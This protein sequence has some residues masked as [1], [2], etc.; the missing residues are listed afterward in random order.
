[1]KFSYQLRYFFVKNKFFKL[2]YYSAP[3]RSFAIANGEKSSYKLALGQLQKFNP[4]AKQIT[5][6]PAAKR[7]QEKF[8]ENNLILDLDWVVPKSVQMSYGSG[9]Q[10]FTAPAVYVGGLSMLFQAIRVAE[11]ACLKKTK[12][13]A[14]FINDAQWPIY[15]QSGLQLHA[16]GTQYPD[17]TTWYL[18]KKIIESNSLL[19]KKSPFD[20]DYDTLHLP[21]GEKF[22]SNPIYNSYYYSLFFLKQIVHDLASVN[23]IGFNDKMLAK[24]VIQALNSYQELNEKIL[25]SIGKPITVH[26]GRLF[27]SRDLDGIFMR[28][29]KWREM[30]IPV[31]FCSID[32]I[33]AKTILRL[34]GERPIYAFGMFGKKPI[35][36]ADGYVKPHIF[37]TSIQYAM[38]CFPE[39]FEYKKARLDKIFLD[40]KSKKPYKLEVTDSSK[41]A[42]EMEVSDFQGSLG[43]AEVFEAGRKERACKEFT[44]TGISMNFVLTISLEKLVKRKLGGTKDREFVKKFI[45][46]NGIIPTAG[47]YNL[48]VTIFDQEIIFENGEEFVKLYCRVTEGANFNVKGVADKRD[49]FNVI[50]KLEIF[51]EGAIELVPAGSCTRRTWLENMPRFDGPFLNGQSGLGLSFAALDHNR[52]WRKPASKSEAAGV[53]K[54]SLASDD[55]YGLKSGAKI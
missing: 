55:R 11:A 33:E 36:S 29:K 5:P 41:L 2:R 13:K 6:F 25:T 40:S 27:F 21:L 26:N 38:Q 34:D 39:N 54:T 24:A 47:L 48:H 20:V 22:F 7:Y 35:V 1:M 30:S 17:Y 50:T 37:E 44:A 52:F 53:A 31:E 32:Q 18:L 4:E 3:N 45:L 49:F 19:F 16:H 10:N 9:E 46:N 28:F 15:K 8:K 51:Y 12:D 23:R 43:H 14:I 42:Y